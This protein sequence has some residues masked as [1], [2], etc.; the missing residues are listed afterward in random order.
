MTSAGIDI[1]GPLP[2]DLQSPDLVYVAG[3]TAA[4][5]EPQAAKALVDFLTGP[6][7]VPVVKAKGLEPP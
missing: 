4:S 2:A 6:A 7:A 1:V 5:K 3:V